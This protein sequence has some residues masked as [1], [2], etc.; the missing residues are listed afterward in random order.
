MKTKLIVVL[1][2]YNE[3]ESLPSLLDRWNF[4]INEYNLN[5]HILIIN[6]G[7]VDKTPD[8]GKNYKANFPVTVVDVY[9]NK[10]LANAIREGFQNAVEIA[11]D[12]DIISLMD[13]DDT[14]NP[15]LIIRMINTI[16]EGADIVIASRYRDGSRIYGLSGF[17]KFLSWGASI[18]FRIL[19]NIKGVR[20]Y[21][22]GYRAYRA[23]LLKDALSLYKDKF[24]EQQGFSAMSE[25]LVKLKKFK[26]I[27]V[28]VPFILRYD[29][30]M[31]TSKMKLFKTIR[32]T[33]G[34]LTSK[35]KK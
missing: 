31:G 5:A 34:L 33:I 26:P 32:Q 28:E 25:V 19:V 35:K 21:T 1:P 22:C 17:R 8:I 4:I 13:A 23:K 20:D 27:V 30:K 3:E 16:H 11:G 7:S 10:G 2:A 18:L 12:N 24:I 6:D 15:G 14:H 29:Q 9:P